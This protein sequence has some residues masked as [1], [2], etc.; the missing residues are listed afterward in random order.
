VAVSVYVDKQT[1]TRF[2]YAK[3]FNLPVHQKLEF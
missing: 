2:E 3:N 1:K